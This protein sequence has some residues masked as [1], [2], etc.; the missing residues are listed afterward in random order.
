[1]KI[2]TSIF[3]K[4]SGIREEDIE[5]KII[6]PRLME[7]ATRE[8]KQIKNL[9]D[10]TKEDQIVAPLIGFLN[11][12][13]GNG[14]LILGIK[15]EKGIPTEIEQIDSSLIR[16]AEQLRSIITDSIAA[17]PRIRE[18]F[19]L[20]IVPVLTKGN[21]K[22]YL[23]ETERTDE[24]CV[25]Y[26]KITQRAYLRRNDETLALTLP[27]ILEMVARKNFPKIFVRF[28]RKMETESGFIF[29]VAFVN[30][31]LKPGRY[32][33]AL[34]KFFYENDFDVTLQGTTVQDVSDLNPGPRKT[35]QVEKQFGTSLVYPVQFNVFGELRI[36]PRKDFQMT[37]AVRV[38][39]NE[40]ITTQ[41]IKMRSENNNISIR[42]SFKQFTP[43]L[44]IQ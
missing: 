28:Y 41:E 27:E 5:E 1:M 44:G 16:N 14:L 33:M 37:I 42:E 23:I 11:A 12:L 39:E 38:Y 15:D 18:F 6:I 21:G 8:Y 9:N 30:E 36:S 31:G 40:G 34:I 32:V 7:N 20:S 29:N 19:R 13:E 4:E 22:I 3:G 35:Y 26:S 43:Y 10:K 24:C 25:Y 17:L 2:I